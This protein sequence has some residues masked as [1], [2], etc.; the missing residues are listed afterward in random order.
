MTG[1]CQALNSR[2]DRVVAFGDDVNDLALFEQ[3]DYAIAVSNAAPE[4]LTKANQVI[5]SNDSGSVIDYLAQ[6]FI[7][8]TKF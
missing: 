3:A 7:R 1:L 5:Q 6:Y 4:V 8:K 2:W